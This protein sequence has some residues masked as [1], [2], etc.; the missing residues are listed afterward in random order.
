MTHKICSLD[1]CKLYESVCVREE[2]FF[3]FRQEFSIILEGG[4]VSL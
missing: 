4:I 2:I 3:R 1:G